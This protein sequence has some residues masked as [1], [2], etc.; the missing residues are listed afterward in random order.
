MVCVRVVCVCVCL[1][2]C[3]SVCLSVCVCLCVCLP[4]RLSVCLSEF[5]LSSPAISWGVVLQTWG[6]DR[7]NAEQK[8][9]PS[10]PAHTHTRARAR[11]PR[12][13]QKRNREHCSVACSIQCFHSDSTYQAGHFAIR[14]GE[15]TANFLVPPDAWRG[16]NTEDRKPTIT[17]IKRENRS[18]NRRGKCCDTRARHCRSRTPTLFC[19]L[20]TIPSHP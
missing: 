13:K 9:T 16:T 1:F 14:T 20:E 2:V 10:S 11:T 19:T 3:L 12:A 5:A 18:M 15:N 4:L 8:P 7:R 17:G 6:R